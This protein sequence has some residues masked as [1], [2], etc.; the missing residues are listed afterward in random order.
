MNSLLQAAGNGVPCLIVYTHLY[1]KKEPLWTDHKSQR[2]QSWL[3]QVHNVSFEMS[4]CP[5]NHSQTDGYPEKTFIVE[6]NLSI[7]GC[8]E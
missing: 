3:T 2:N 1:S 4:K 7:A 8:G 5:Q 6:M